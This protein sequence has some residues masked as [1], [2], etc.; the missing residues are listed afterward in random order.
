MKYC[1]MLY[2]SKETIRGKKVKLISKRRQNV[3]EKPTSFCVLHTLSRPSVWN[4]LRVGNDVEVL[5]ASARRSIAG[6]DP[7]SNLTAWCRASP[8]R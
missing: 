4:R 3:S 8:E 2:D 7:V 1:T 6:H 5:R